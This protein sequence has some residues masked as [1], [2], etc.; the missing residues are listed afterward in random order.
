M[1]EKRKGEVHGLVK[2]GTIS[3]INTKL[4]AVRSIQPTIASKRRAKLLEDSS[5]S[6]FSRHIAP[7]Y[8]GE[9]RISEHQRLEPS[10]TSLRI[11]KGFVVNM[12][13]H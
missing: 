5:G 13:K 10:S 9:L 3:F 11:L 1:R 2:A 8:I 4:A 6:Q 12:T 7:G